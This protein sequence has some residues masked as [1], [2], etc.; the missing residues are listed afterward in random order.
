LHGEKN[1]KI[2]SFLE[3][4]I[5]DIEG[6]VFQTN[7]N[8]KFQNWKSVTFDTL[9]SRKKGVGRL[10][11]V[12]LFPSG[13]EAEASGCTAQASGASES[14]RRIHRASRMPLRDDPLR[15]RYAQR[16]QAELLS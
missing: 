10:T 12:L 13:W 6:N 15:D 4:N 5:Q 16:A 11:T 2:R 14:F 8:K 7:W 1:T 9:L 3:K